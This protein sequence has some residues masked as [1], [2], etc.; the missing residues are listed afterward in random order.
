M[1]SR[2][3][4]DC[5]NSNKN[6]VARIELTCLHHENLAGNVSQKRSRLHTNTKESRLTWLLVP[7]P[8]RQRIRI[9]FLISNEIVLLLS[10]L[11]IVVSKCA[12]PR[13]WRY[14]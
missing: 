1:K 8:W 13:R 9:L 11:V 12:E 5:S 6:T 14:Y 10:N 3:I 4:L 7:M 2:V